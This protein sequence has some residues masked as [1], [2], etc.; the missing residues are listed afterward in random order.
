[1]PNEPTL[2]NYCD[3]CLGEATLSDDFTEAV[4]LGELG[5]DT[6]FGKFAE[7]SALRFTVFTKEFPATFVSSEHKP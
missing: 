2:L 5:T 1:M 4:G 6:D 3:S 7:P